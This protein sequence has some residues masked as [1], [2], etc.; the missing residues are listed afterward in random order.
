[1]WQIFYM[2]LIV[3]LWHSTNICIEGEKK[4]DFWKNAEHYSF[5]AY[6]NVIKQGTILFSFSDMLISFLPSTDILMNYVFIMN[7]NN[8]SIYMCGSFLA[9]MPVVSFETFN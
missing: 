1:M 8:W 7:F 3:T 5:E 6:D 4:T 2:L 9:Y